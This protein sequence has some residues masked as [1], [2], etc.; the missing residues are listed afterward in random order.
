MKKIYQR[1]LW[2]GLILTMGIYS[3]SI[4]AETSLRPEVKHLHQIQEFPIS[5]PGIRG[6]SLFKTPTADMIL[7]HGEPG[8]KLHKHTRSDHFV[9]ILKGNGEVRLGDK[10]ESVAEG[11]LV[12]IPKE[13]PHSILKRD[14]DEFVFLAISSPPLDLDDFIWFEK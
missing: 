9:Y 6:A 1:W 8:T 2:F 12:L 5:I 13:L 14:N 11:D 3:I 7:T 4:G 10:K